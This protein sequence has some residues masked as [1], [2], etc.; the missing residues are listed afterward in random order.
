MAEE[1][2]QP[3]QVAPEPQG[4]EHPKETDWKAEARKWEARAKKS[5]NAELELE[6]LKQ[7]QMTEQEKLKAKAD[8]AEAELAAIKAEQQ[9][10]TDARELSQ[11]DGVPVELLE[12]C[13]DREAMVRFA[14]VYKSVAPAVHSAAPATPP[15]V[16]TSGDVKPS[17]G[18]IFAEAVRG[19]F[20]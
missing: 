20:K 5:A 18:D 11:R 16:V 14:N 1:T 7:A 6:A 17:E 2:K 13:T 3:E 9:R 8:K 12:F 4:D 15:R 10:I 19:L